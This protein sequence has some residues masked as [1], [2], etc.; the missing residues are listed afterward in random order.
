MQ[1]AQHTLLAQPLA[2]GLPLAW[3]ANERTNEPGD[4]HRHLCDLPML[5]SPVDEIVLSK[6]PS[7][8]VMDAGGRG[9][10]LPC[11][12][13]MAHHSKCPVSGFGVACLFGLQARGRRA[14]ADR[15]KSSVTHPPMRPCV[16]DG[17]N[18]RSML[19]RAVVQDERDVWR[20]G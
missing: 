14:R 6:C 11:L 19:W 1:Y 5:P 12:A 2:S 8:V 16:A 15:Q 13:D 7:E 17:R 3:L 9:G 18:G 10:C 20:R 4:D